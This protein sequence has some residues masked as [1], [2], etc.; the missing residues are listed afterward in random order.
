MIFHGQIS[1]FHRNVIR[2]GDSIWF[3]FYITL[4]QERRNFELLNCYLVVFVSKPEKRQSKPCPSEKSRFCRVSLTSFLGLRERA[5]GMP[6]GLG[7]YFVMVTQVMFS[8]VV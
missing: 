2:A 4:R 3:I 7:H 8:V 6:V 1:F 5:L